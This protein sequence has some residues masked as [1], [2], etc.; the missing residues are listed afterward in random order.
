MAAVV[1]KTDPRIN[2]VT[3][4][5]VLN[6]V[7]ESAVLVDVTIG[8]WGGT[9]TDPD[10]V[11]DVKKA[12]NATGDVGKFIKNLMVGADSEFKACR[13]A[14]IAVRLRHYALTLPWVTDPHSARKTGARLLPHLLFQRYQSEMSELR[15]IAFQKLDELCAIYPGLVKTAIGN[16]NTMA[17][18][19]QYPSV[20][21]LRAAFRVHFDF[22]PVP[23]GARFRGLP[24]HTLERLGRQLDRRH[25]RQVGEANREILLRAEEPLRNL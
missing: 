3:E 15:R 22:T 18:A 8:V 13:S 7:R 19:G 10:V 9:R 1:T 16:L 6:A 21:Q 23:E 11:D 14:F 12:H 5:D 25:M 24:E 2:T 4:E 17:D 20:D